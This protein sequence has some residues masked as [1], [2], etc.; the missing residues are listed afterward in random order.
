MTQRWFPDDAPTPAANDET[1]PFWEAARE[2]RL[3]FQRCSACKT[4]RHPPSPICP[5]CQSFDA[6]WDEVPGTGTVFSYAVVHT[7][8]HPS[9]RGSIPYACVLVEIDGTDGAVRFLSNLV[10]TPV[11]SVAVG[12]RVEVAWEDMSDQLT[13]PRFRPTA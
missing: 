10:D 11:E 7:P 9:L 1:R 3:V 4:W 6:T 5:S 2:H 8:H 12:Q 13:V